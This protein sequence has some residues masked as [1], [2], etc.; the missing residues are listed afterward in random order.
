MDRFR[1][2]TT[3]VAVA[4]EGAFNGA[5]RRLGSSPP[6]ITRMV[7]ALEERL[8]VRLFTRTTRQVA[9]TEA[10]AR[11]RED[12]QRILAELEEAESLAT[13]ARA[14]ASGHLRLT[15]PV[16]FGQR[17]LAPLLCD[18][19]DAH[20]A[21]SA[22]ALF[23]DRNVNLLDEGIDV[24]L[25]I[26][27]LADSSLSASRV[28]AVRRVI[29]AAPGYLNRKGTPAKPETLKDH[30]IIFPTSIVEIPS[31]TFVFG[32]K[33]RPIRLRPALSLNTMAATIDA[34]LAGWGITRALSYQVADD[35]AKGRLIEVLGAYEDR[36]MPIHLLHAEGRR[37]AAKIRS[38]VDFATE[39]LRVEAERLLA[40]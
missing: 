8:G 20:P 3:F 38:F 21:V 15:A 35:L 32:N 29:V 31:W 13:G 1:E 24:A 9:L 7:N 19:L 5:A 40:R 2:L 6:A 30:R 23:V 34:A 10:G 4:E 39:R 22:S 28:G 36:I 14:T 37:A 33:R 12:A 26:G 27:E 16:M 18:Y 17:F 11:L 25:R